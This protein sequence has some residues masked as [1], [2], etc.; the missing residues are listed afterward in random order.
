LR[1]GWLAQKIR[2]TAKAAAT[3]LV[4]NDTQI[5]YPEGTLKRESSPNLLSPQAP[6]PTHKKQRPFG[7]IKNQEMNKKPRHQSGEIL[8]QQRAG[9]AI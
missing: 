2:C 5:A 7:C 8:T 6:L 9:Y 4:R 1:H 3:I